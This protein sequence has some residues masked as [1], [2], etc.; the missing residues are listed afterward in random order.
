MQSRGVAEHSHAAQRD[1]PVDPLGLQQPFS[2]GYCRG[3]DYFLALLMRSAAQDHRPP[4]AGDQPD[5]RDVRVADARVFR[6]HRESPKQRGVAARTMA[7][8][9]RRNDRIVALSW[10]P[11]ARG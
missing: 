1:W 9:D 8:V 5:E 6:H 4:V 11:R 2:S 7:R 3:S 10:G